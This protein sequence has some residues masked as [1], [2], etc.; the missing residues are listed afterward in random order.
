MAGQLLQPVFLNALKV[1][2]ITRLHQEGIRLLL[3]LIFP[4][5]HWHWQELSVG[6]A[7]RLE[8]SEAGSAV[9]LFIAR[10]KVTKLYVELGPTLPVGSTLAQYL[11]STPEMHTLILKF[12][13]NPGDGYLQAI[14]HSLELN[15][16][17]TPQSS[18]LH[19]LYLIEGSLQNE[20]VRQ[21]LK[22]HPLI[23]KLRLIG[24][25]FEPS[26][27]ELL[28]WLRPLVSEVYCIIQMNSVDILY[29]YSTMS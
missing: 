10:C 19:S 13:S 4:Q 26:E 5:C 3:P 17:H 14:I 9:R 20:T 23:K 22:A 6:V 24:C 29:W 2:D 12:L 16:E 1:I 28:G 7:M 8:T 27:E 18:Y 25:S 11:A 15:H 21:I